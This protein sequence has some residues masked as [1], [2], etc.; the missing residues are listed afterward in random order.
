MKRL[1]EVWRRTV[2][3][4]LAVFGVWL[5]AVAINKVSWFFWAL[6][7]ATA[8][9]LVLFVAPSV[10]ERMGRI[11]KYPSLLASYQEMIESLERARGDLEAS[12]KEAEKAR[13]DGRRA[14]HRD[15][16]GAVLALGVEDLEIEGVTLVGSEV[17]LLTAT[18]G[19]RL[20]VGA[21]FLV[22]DPMLPSPMGVVEVMSMADG[23]AM[24]RC[25][26]RSNPRFWAEIAERADIDSSPPPRAR[27]SP[28]KIS[29]VGDSTESRGSP[30]TSKMKGE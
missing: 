17:A 10:S 12:R 4:L 22:A 18:S 14:G 9:A 19:G 25:V 2:L 5:G 24:L 8:I 11:R 15:A 29:D 21:R 13:I 23:V 16:M 1:G 30:E 20:K 27:L 6:G 7:A 26:E 28:Y 3:P